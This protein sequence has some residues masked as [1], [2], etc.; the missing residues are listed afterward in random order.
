[1]TP[2]ATANAKS[3][4]RHATWRLRDTGPKLKRES[5]S[6]AS[7]LRIE[8]TCRDAPPGQSDFMREMMSAFRSNVF[9]F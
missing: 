7:D 8:L 4:L 6:N 2:S 9:G 3:S 1:M 5:Q